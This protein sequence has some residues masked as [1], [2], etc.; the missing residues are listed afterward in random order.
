MMV[1]EQCVLTSPRNFR[2]EMMTHY[3]D[4]HTLQHHWINEPVH[5]HY[6]LGYHYN[7]SDQ[8]E[9]QMQQEG[10]E[11][12]HCE[13]CTN[14]HLTI[15]YYMHCKKKKEFKK[16]CM[17]RCTTLSSTRSTVYNKNC[18]NSVSFQRSITC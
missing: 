14:S 16:M 3:Q 18:L 11:H 9:K 8:I 2:M 17:F 10:H 7:I 1:Y 13:Y 12:T 4:N 5:E 6:I 15:I